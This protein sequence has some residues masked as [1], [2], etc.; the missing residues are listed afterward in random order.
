MSFAISCMAF[1]P[2]GVAAMPSP[3]IFAMMFTAMGSRADDPAQVRKQ[4]IKERCHAPGK[5]SHQSGPGSDLHD[6]TPE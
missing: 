1:N 2:A 4:K 6:A 5:P 3:S